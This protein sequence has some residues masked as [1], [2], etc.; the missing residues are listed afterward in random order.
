MYEPKG[1][2]GFGYDP[3][4]FVKSENKGMAELTDLEKSKIS[5]RAKALNCVLNWLKENK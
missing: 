4:F 1:K 5:H 2:G 3:I